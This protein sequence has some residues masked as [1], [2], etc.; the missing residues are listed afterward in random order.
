MGIS[1]ENTDPLSLTKADMAEQLFTTMGISRRESKVI[2]DGFFDILHEKLSS[3]DS[4]KIAGFGNFT[5]REKSARPGRNPR[6]GELAV[7]AARRVVT[8]T[9]SQ[10]IKTLLI[11]EGNDGR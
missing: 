11:D 8:F 4:V 7:I 10:K 3:G 5:V 2:V 1:E 9:A 6:T